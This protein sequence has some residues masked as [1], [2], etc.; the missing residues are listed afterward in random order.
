MSRVPRTTFRVAAI[1]MAAALGSLSGVAPANAGCL[2]EYG[3]CGDCARA[4]M[5]DAIRG[6]S[7]DDAMDAYVDAIDCDI[8]LMHC[9][10][11]DSH[12]SYECGV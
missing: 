11:N 7:I 1:V 8:D 5:I 2:R 10:L 4:A 12:H 6:K 9:I 3:K